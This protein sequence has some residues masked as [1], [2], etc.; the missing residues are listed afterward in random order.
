VPRSEPTLWPLGARRNEL[1]GASPVS[2]RNWGQTADS[3]GPAGPMPIQCNG[4]GK[5]FRSLTREGFSI[6]FQHETAVTQMRV[7]AT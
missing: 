6:D 5:C 1:S 3:I 2:R 7:S 4:S